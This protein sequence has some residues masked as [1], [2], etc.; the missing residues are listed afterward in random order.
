MRVDKLLLN[1]QKAKQ[2]CSLHPVR[3]DKQKYDIAL[4]WVW[5]AFSRSMPPGNPGF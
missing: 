4:A 3:E 1:L 5:K 2:Q